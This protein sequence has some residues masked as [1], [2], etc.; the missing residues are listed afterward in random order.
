MNI[1]RVALVVLIAAS[2]GGGAVAQWKWRDRNGGIQYSDLPPPN[3]T[4][5]KDI[6]EKPQSF[7]RR[8]A[9]APAVAASAAASAPRTLEAEL[10]VRRRQADIEKAEKTNKELAAR[11]AEDER[12][13]LLKAENCRRARASL[14]TLEDG[15]RIGRTNE[16]GE[17]EVLDDRTRAE[18]TVRVRTVIASD[19]ATGR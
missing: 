13:A 3:G 6:L 11:Q 10:E 14:R 4:P 1:I 15:A 16:K 19:C 7:Q 2:V 9:S 17:R 5:D 18:E 12:I 8:A